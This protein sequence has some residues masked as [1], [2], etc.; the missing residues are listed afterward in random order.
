M[1]LSPFV[2]G[3]SVVPYGTLGG[4]S[5]SYFNAAPVSGLGLHTNT[6]STG[7]LWTWDS[8]YSGTRPGAFQGSL[9]KIPP[10]ASAGAL[11]ALTG[12]AA[13][14]QPLTRAETEAVANVP[15]SPSNLNVPA[16]PA[17]VAPKVAPDSVPLQIWE[18]EVLAVHEQEGLMEV[19]LRSKFGRENAHTGEIDLDY[20]HKQDRDLVR[21]GAVFYLTL[22]KR[23]RHGTV[24]NAEILRFRRLP[25]WTREQVERVSREADALASKFVPKP[26]AE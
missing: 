25:A 4:L 24:E 14:R 20:V 11:F 9:E 12:E 15:R 2:T 21:P 7:G 18:G 1:T 5:A 13:G 26:R 23:T 19:L 8:A 10:V 16:L 17:A 22:F 6:G 3:T